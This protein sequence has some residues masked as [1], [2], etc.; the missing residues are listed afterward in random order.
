MG[1]MVVLA[2]VYGL[3]CSGSLRFASV[4][5]SRVAVSKHVLSSQRQG[6]GSL[7][8]MAHG[9]LDR[10]AHILLLHQRASLGDRRLNLG[11][12]PQGALMLGWQPW[13]AVLF[14]P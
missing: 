6:G 12:C 8:M 7:G 14:S 5:I 10:T 3:G 11:G 1:A 9:R 4:T 2:L 13:T